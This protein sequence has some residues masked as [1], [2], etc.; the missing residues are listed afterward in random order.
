MEI[1]GISQ[2]QLIDINFRLLDEN[3]SKGKEFRTIIKGR[4]FMTP[5][6]LGY[7]SIPNGIVE[8]SEGTF[9]KTN[10]FG[11]TVLKD[12]VHRRDLSKSFNDWN[13]AIYYI[14]SLV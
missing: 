8:L 11:V 6:I 3:S 14:K 7:I 2:K 13:D 9:V 5:N 12:D 4:N 10:L 1:G